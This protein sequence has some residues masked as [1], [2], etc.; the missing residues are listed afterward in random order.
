MP[1]TFFNLHDTILNFY[2]PDRRDKK[3]NILM[4]LMFDNN[5]GDNYQYNDPRDILFQP[6]KDYLRQIDSWK[7]GDGYHSWY[8]GKNQNSD[9]YR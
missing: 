6:L 2:K 5:D 9:Y 4:Q 8:Y 1:L 7:G 3:Y